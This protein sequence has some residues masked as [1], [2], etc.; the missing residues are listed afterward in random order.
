MSSTASITPWATPTPD[1][2]CRCL[3]RLSNR[4]TRIAIEACN[5]ADPENGRRVDGYVD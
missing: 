3:V 4:L 1:F 5:S 2:M